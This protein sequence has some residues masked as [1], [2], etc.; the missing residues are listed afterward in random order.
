MWS[1]NAQHTSTSTCLYL[2]KHTHADTLTPRSFAARRNQQY[3]SVK[4][5]WVPHLTDALWYR[6][7]QSKYTRELA[8]I[9]QWIKTFFV[10][11]VYI[12]SLVP[13][14]LGERKK[15]PGIHCLRMREKP[16]DLWGIVYHRLQTINLYRIALKHIWLELIP[17][18]SSKRWGLR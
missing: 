11:L 10:S 9:H 14:A 5:V 8:H 18:M 16:H 4:C 1:V 3:A 7:Q 12:T 2:Y 6:T 15:W 13:R 17:R